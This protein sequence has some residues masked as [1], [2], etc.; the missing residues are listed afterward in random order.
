MPMLVQHIR[1]ES[2]TEDV[3][4]HHEAL[5]HRWGYWHLG[6]IISAFEDE[7]P[8]KG[9]DDFTSYGDCHGYV[10]KVR[11]GFEDPTDGERFEILPG[12]FF[13]FSR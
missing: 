3:H 10:F 1:P 9:A 4:G 6:C 11:H 7:N 13:T 12:D 5:T 2:P 8:L